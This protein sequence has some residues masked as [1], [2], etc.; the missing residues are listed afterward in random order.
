MTNHS[1]CCPMSIP[2]PLTRPRVSALPAALLLAASLS[3]AGC[4]SEPA[5]ATSAPPAADSRAAAPAPAAGGNPAPIA[6]VNRSAARE[7]AIQILLEAAL[8]REPLHRAN[9]LEGLLP[10]PSRVEAVARAALADD[11][12]GVRYAACIVIGKLKQKSSLP[13]VEPLV[14]DP[15]PRVQ[16]AALY[17]ISRC[18][19]PVNFTPLAR[20]LQHPDYRVR[21]EAARVLGDLGNRTATPM[22]RAAA[23]NVESGDLVEAKLFRLQIAEAMVKLGEPDVIDSVRAALF[24]PT[25]NDYEVS[26]LAAQILGELKDQRA[27]RDLIRVIEQRADAAQATSTPITPPGASQPSSAPAD[28]REYAQPRELRLAAASALGKMGYPDGVYVA[29][30]FAADPDP[31]VRQQ[32]ALVLGDAGLPRSLA[33]LDGM[34]VDPSPEVRIAAAA[35]ALKL[36]ERR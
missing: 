32:A 29:D 19:K 27:A 30:D 7:R 33:Q 18:G 36:I 28:T 17:A 20:A 4:K 14:N 21:A 5:H 35:A 15:D 25:R 24:P 31:L 1:H 6:Q 11:N 13:M 26:V 23:A 10:V 34:M 12:V 22:L 2:V 16:G 9:A 3:A 8:S